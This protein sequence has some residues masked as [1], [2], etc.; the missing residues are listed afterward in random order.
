VGE[1]RQRAGICRSLDRHNPDV[2]PLEMLAASELFEGASPAD[3]E[4]LARSA[5]IKHYNHGDLIFATGDQAERM[6]LVLTGEVVVSRLGPDGEEYVVELFTTGDVLGSFH[7]FEPSPIRLLDARAA[8][9]T[10]CWSVSRQDFIRLLERRPKLMLLMLRTYSRWIVRRDLQD[11]DRSFRNVGAQVATRLLHLADQF[12]KPSKDGLQ[13]PL[14]VTETTLANMIGASREN[15][16]RAVAKLQRSGE[17]RRQRGLFVL[18]RPEEL[19]T[20][21]S[22]V[23]D[24]EARIVSSKKR[25]NQP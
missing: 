15:V 10:S 16:S 11:A 12:G 24:E 2:E 13:I 9:A 4:P 19:R 21:Y 18:L 1:Q 17:V 5:A 22:W 6:Y 14:H 7:F 8:D 20:R 23:S 25:V 3:F